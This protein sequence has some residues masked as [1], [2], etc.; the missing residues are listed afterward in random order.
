MFRA[1]K[2]PKPSAFEVGGSVPRGLSVNWCEFLKK[3]TCEDAVIELRATSGAMTPERK[4]CYAI[5]NVGEVKEVIAP[6]VHTLPQIVHS[7]K[8]ANP[9]HADVVWHPADDEQIKADLASLAARSRLAP[10]LA[11][12]PWWQD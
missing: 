5:L 10:G 1:S 2:L 9:S 8:P 4:S 7:P 11:D 12:D 6:H 3:P